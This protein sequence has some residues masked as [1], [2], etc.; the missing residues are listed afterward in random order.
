MFA[1]LPLP[2]T[3]QSVVLMVFTIRKLCTYCAQLHCELIFHQNS[4]GQINTAKH[5]RI[6]NQFLYHKCTQYWIS[7]V[8]NIT[9]T[10]EMEEQV[11]IHVRSAVPTIQQK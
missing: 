8:I 2:K 1:T 3:V 7:K 9:V 10:Y 6:T 11:R 4:S 5:S